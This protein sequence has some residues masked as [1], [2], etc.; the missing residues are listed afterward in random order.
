MGNVV[1]EYGG[2][3]LE[4]SAGEVVAF[5]KSRSCSYGIAGVTYVKNVHEVVGFLT[6]VRL[7][8]NVTPND[9]KVA[10]FVTDTG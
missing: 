5:N 8:L 2:V 9:A 1:N 4:G 7:D 6:Y 3:V 10:V